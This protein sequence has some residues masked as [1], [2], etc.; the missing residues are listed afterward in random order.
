MTWPGLWPGVKRTSISNPASSSLAPS[1]DVV[2]LVALVRPDA[3]ERH[4]AHDVR[5]HGSLDLAHVHGRARLPCHRRDR[6]HMV[7]VRVGEEH[8]L[9]LEAEFPHRRED[10]L[11][12]VT[13]IEDHRPAELSGRAMKQF[14]CTG[15]TVNMRTSMTGESIEGRPGFPAWFS[16]FPRAFAAAA[17]RRSSPPRGRPVCRCRGQE[18]QPDRLPRRGAQEE[19]GKRKRLTAAIPPRVKAP[20]HVGGW[21]SRCWRRCRR[22]CAPPPASGGGSVSGGRCRPGCRDACACDA[23]APSRTSADAA[24]STCRRGRTRSSGRRRGNR[25][26]PPVARGRRSR[27]R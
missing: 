12:L 10:A 17:G 8:R 27:R 16:S 5:Q 7:E 21:S 20:R 23:D 6:A 18:R 4:V 19:R 3:R 14:S 15:P 1:Q 25:R 2:G 24:S 26:S 22:C 9:D 13:G 11:R